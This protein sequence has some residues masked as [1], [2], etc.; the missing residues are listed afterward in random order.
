MPT[1]FGHKLIKSLLSRR[2]LVVTVANA[3]G[4]FTARFGGAIANFAFTLLIARYL[5]PSQVGFILFTM[6]MALLASLF[7]T[8]NMENG[9]VR[10]LLQPVSRGRFA[11]AAG[12]ITYGRRMLVRLALPVMV[13]FVV[14]MMVSQ[15]L[16]N[17]LT[18]AE[19][20]GVAFAAASVPLL[21]MLRLGTRWGHAL[22]R[23][24]KSMLS[25]ALFRPL[26]LCV[27]TF[28]LVLMGLGLTVDRV[29]LMALVACFLALG[30]QYLL[31]RD[32][33]TF[34]KDTE[35]DVSKS[36]EWLRTGLFL[37]VTILLLD[38]FQNVVIVAAAFGLSDSD[39]ARLGIALRFVGFLRMGL[40]AVN[41]AVS[42][43][44]SRAFAN[45]KRG[46]A[47]HLL[48]L[49]TNLKFWPTLLVTGLVW[50][51]APFMVSLFGE[52]YL[53]AAWALRCFAVLPLVAA[54]FGP[55]IMI[56]N[57]LGEQKDIFRVSAVSLA[58]LVI[59]VPVAGTAFG[60]NGAALAAVLTIFFW[61]WALYDRVRRK[62]GV[63]ASIIAATGWL[64]QALRRERSGFDK[65]SDPQVPAADSEPASLK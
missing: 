47:E 53:S 63:D 51:I 18:Q 60:L 40:M 22:S 31:I 24:L 17:N 25:W 37:S 41:M 35:P 29:L 43:N 7:M 12:F 8:M 54:F 13:I 45:E 39:V 50:W 38:Y 9:A 1:S 33:F 52:D 56:L 58:L 30:F 36:G 19:L 16:K 32:A 59:S 15:S 42:P 65:A 44:I 61:E 64:H 5:V 55:S 4:V 48:S 57:I 6:S 34:M 62:T 23:I 3:A 46:E 28:V 49:S 11:E 2:N 14:L 21:A 20:W 27:L 10:H 26:L